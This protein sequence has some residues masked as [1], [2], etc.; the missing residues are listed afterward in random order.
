MAVRRAL[1]L[2]EEG[3]GAAEGIRTPDPRITNA[4]L[5][6]LSYRGNGAPCTGALVD[7]QYRSRPFPKDL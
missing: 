3:N 7:L 1:G 2:L 5:Y 4:M 6:Q